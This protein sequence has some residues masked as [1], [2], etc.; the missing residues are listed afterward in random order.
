M[1]V[2]YVAVE[3]RTAIRPIFITGGAFSEPFGGKECQKQ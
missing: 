1:T 2:E 3:L